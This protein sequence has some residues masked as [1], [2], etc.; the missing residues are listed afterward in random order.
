MFKVKLGITRLVSKE[1]VVCAVRSQSDF[2]NF[3]NPRTVLYETE[4]VRCLG[5]KIWKILPYSIK[6]SSNLKVFKK[7]A[8][9]ILRRT[10]RLRRIVRLK[11]YS[12]RQYKYSTKPSDGGIFLSFIRLNSCDELMHKLGEIM[13]MELK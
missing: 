7:M 12:V 3:N 2:Y 6:T 13:S 1:S 5:P 10:N 11:N 9:F 4:T 8:A